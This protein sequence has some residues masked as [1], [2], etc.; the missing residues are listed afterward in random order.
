MMFETIEMR[1]IVVKVHQADVG[2]K[3]NLERLADHLAL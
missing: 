3:Q 2:L 1:D